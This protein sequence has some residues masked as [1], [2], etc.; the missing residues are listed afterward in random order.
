MKRGASAETWFYY[1]FDTS[2]I[3]NNA[4]INSIACKSKCYAAGGSAAVPTKWMC[5]F[6]GTTQKGSTYSLST[7]TSERTLTLQSLTLAELRDARIKVYTRRGTSSNVNSNYDVRFYGATLTVKYTTTVT[8]YSVSASAQSISGVTIT[9]GDE[10]E[11]GSNAAITISGASGK[12]FTVTDNG[13]DVTAD[14]TVSGDDYIYTIPSIDA[15]HEIIVIG[16]EEVGQNIYVK[17]NGAWVKATKIFVKQN[18][19]WK[20]GKMFVKGSGTW[21]S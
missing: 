16:N 14:L 19:V 1:H 20:E 5:F 7:S 9:S 2:S 17:Q 11:S 18:G 12:V 15:D 13:V 10:Y 4:Q 21:K 8:Y 3:P 6:S